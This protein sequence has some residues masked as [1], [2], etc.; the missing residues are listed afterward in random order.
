MQLPEDTKQAWFVVTGA[1]KEHWHHPWDDD[2]SNDEQWPYQ[3]TFTGCGAYGAN[4]IF[5]E[6]DFPEDY[7]RHD[8][9]VVINASLARDASSYSSVR[10]QYDMDAISEALGLT[11][12]QL[13]TVKAQS[14][15]N[16]RFGAFNTNGRFV[17]TPLTTTS[18]DINS[19]A[20]DRKYGHWFTSSGNVTD[21]GGSAYVFA[22]WYPS[23]YGCYVGQYPGR[24]VSG[25][26]YTVRHA[27]E[28]TFDGTTYRAI[29]E[30]HLNVK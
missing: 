18:S 5:T 14:T 9:T 29:M 12:A 22:E 16:P 1:P 13:Q 7:Q 4:R 23:A 20:S 17:V 19:T 8:T 10:V 30:V 11:T 2:A 25:R 27:F 24:L 26:T 28:Y 6:A 15:A 3:V 21:Y